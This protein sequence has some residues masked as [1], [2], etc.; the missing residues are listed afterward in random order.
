MSVWLSIPGALKQ[1][2]IRM[3]IKTAVPY[4][5]LRGKADEAIGLYE[6]ALGAKVGVLQR[7]GEVMNDCP[8]AMKRW[9]MHAELQVGS[10]TIMLSDGGPREGEPTAGTVN[11]AL[12][13]D[14]AAQA[15]ASFEALAKGGTTVE[16]LAAA[17]WGGLFGALTDPYGIGWMFTS[18]AG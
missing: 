13:F 8:D 6:R 5:I 11:V 14:D 10:A 1:G 16:P 18:A 7:F 4:L 12:A 9:V 2:A 15:H 3:A 17:P